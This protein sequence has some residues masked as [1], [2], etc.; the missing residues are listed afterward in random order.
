VKIQLPNAS[1]ED[2]KVVDVSGLEKFAKQRGLPAEFLAEQGLHIA[3]EHAPKPGWIAIPYPH[4]SGL[5]HT[6]YRNP[7]KGTPKY[8]QPPG[9][10]VHLYNPMRLGPNAD[11]VV[12]T[13]GEVDCLVLCF[14]GYP[15]VGIP[16]TQSSAERFK[17]SWRLLFTDA[18]VVVAFDND[19]PGQEAANRLADA[20][21]P[22]SRVL[23][24]PPGLDVNEWF[25]GDREGLVGAL[26]ALLEAL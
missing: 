18:R 3:D 10:D 22:L 2:E 13:E 9:T 17:R 4:L 6:R 23:V 21:E 8:W 24:P 16:G 19:A 20:F 1:V 26:D 25:L 11:L 14:L 12:F 15:A 7:G 5:W